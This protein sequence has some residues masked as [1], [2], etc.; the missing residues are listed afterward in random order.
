MDGWMDGSLK[1]E[2]EKEGRIDGRPPAIELKTEM[3]MLSL[4]ALEKGRFLLHQMRMLL[5]ACI[6]LG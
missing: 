6:E 1:R 4:A 2:R 3:G 5:C